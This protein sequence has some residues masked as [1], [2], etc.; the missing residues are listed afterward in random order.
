[1]RSRNRRSRIEGS[2]ILCGGPSMSGPSSRWESRRP[3]P[4]IR[5]PPAPGSGRPRSPRPFHDGSHWAWSPP[6]SARSC[7]GLGQASRLRRSV[8]SSALLSFGPDGRQG[9]RSCRIDFPRP[10]KASLRAGRA[11]TKS[12]CTMPGYPG[13]RPRKPGGGNPTS[14]V[15]PE[16]GEPPRP[17]RSAESWIFR[18]GSSLAVPASRKTIQ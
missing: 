15:G 9:D 17:G 5:G 12:P 6:P 18:L 4:R 13:I 14:G 7:G 8:P 1:M 10:H 11:S 16:G 3:G 2:L